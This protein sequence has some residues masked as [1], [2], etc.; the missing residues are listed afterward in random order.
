MTTSQV[1]PYAS[2]NQ[3]MP[4]NTLGKQD[5]L[6]LLVMQLRHQ[7]PLDPMKGTEFASQLAQFSSLEQLT[8]LN[9]TMMAGVD[10]NAILAQ[11]INNGL[12]ATFIGKNVRAAVDTFKYSG[13]GEMK[14]GYELPMNAETVMVKIYDEN[15]K[16]I[17]T[18]NGTAAKGDNTVTW[19][20][21][22]EK[23]SGV[24]AGSYRFEVEAVDSGGN[25]VS[26]MKYIFGNITGV[27]FKA[28]GTVFV[29]DGME[30]ALSNILE[31]MKG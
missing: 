2:L 27:R 5:F 29:I 1:N 6:N 7:D 28:E 30:I 11:S 31:I 12:S 9:Q 23:D 10:A 15:G 25:P 20:G 17:K 4:K 16:L 24:A 8:N 21:T 3:R 13:S 22:N 14:I 26:S 19:D 18:V